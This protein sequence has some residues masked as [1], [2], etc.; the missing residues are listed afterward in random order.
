MK[1]ERSHSAPRNLHYTKF[2]QNLK[3]SWKYSFDSKFRLGT[4][5]KEGCQASVYRC[6]SRITRQ[7]Y[8]VKIYDVQ[9]MDAKSLDH[10]SQELA[11]YS[12]L[13]HS[14][15]VE[16]VDISFSEGKLY[17]V[18]ELLGGGDLKEYLKST[19]RPSEQASA[20]V[21]SGLL[22]GV[23]YLHMRDIV[24]RDL[25]PAN[26][27]F[28]I[29][30]EAYSGDAVWESVKVVDF[31]FAA[32]TKGNSLTQSCGSPLFMA[33][34]TI[35]VR[36][37]RKPY[38]KPADLW[39]VGVIAYILLSGKYPFSGDET[40]DVFDIVQ[41]GVYP[42]LPAITWPRVSSAALDFVERLLVVKPALRPT[43]SEALRH[44]WLRHRS[45]IPRSPLSTQGLSEG[46]ADSSEGG[47]SSFGEWGLPPGRRPVR[48]FPEPQTPVRHGFYTSRLS[49]ELPR[50]SSQGTLGARYE[51]IPLSRRR[52][53]TSANRPRRGSD[54]PKPLSFVF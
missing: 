3:A 8:A 51:V 47:S 15:I 48:S 26:M 28:P 5:I 41:R 21:I 29:H 49:P 33:P 20:L 34:E 40:E 4:K 43:A 24:H 42:P 11:L 10:L 13:K 39:S 30:P 44:P 52:T 32:V 46:E 53:P 50:H 23:E 2:V 27:M 9:S 16:S 37:T 54:L 14:N 38:G 45:P 35:A 36:D 18:Q 22:Q 1:S 6:S 19:G 31:G 7:S 25:K 17:I 12:G